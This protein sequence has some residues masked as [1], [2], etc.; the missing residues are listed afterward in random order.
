MRLTK[1]QTTVA[2]WVATGLI[3]LF[4]T[5][6]ALA[7]LTQEAVQLECRR[8]GF[9]DYFRVELALAKLLGALA[10]L[11]PVG[12]RPKEW[13]YA[14]FVILLFSAIVAHPASGESFRASAGP[15]GLLAVLAA[16]Y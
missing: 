11:L 9:P 15:V 13:A 3:A 12:P 10:L 1:H 5:K 14:G 4:M 16:S 6:S 2:Y 8:L 7:Y